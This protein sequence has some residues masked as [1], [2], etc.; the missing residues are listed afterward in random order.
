MQRG[1][2]EALRARLELQDALKIELDL[3]AGHPDLLPVSP[4]DHAAAANP[5]PWLLAADAKISSG[6]LSEEAPII[7]AA[8]W[9]LGRRPVPAI[10]LVERILYR[11]IID[12]L[13]KGLAQQR[14]PRDW[15]TFQRAPMNSGHQDGF[16]L[17]LDLAHFYATLNIELLGTELIERT[18]EWEATQALVSFLGR[19]SPSV[20]GIPQGSRASDRVGDTFAQTLHHRL[21][22]RGLECWQ[23]ADDY[24]IWAP[25]Y[26]AAIRALDSFDEEARKLGLFLNERKTTIKSLQAYEESV[27]RPIKALTQAWEDKRSEMADVDLYSDVE[28]EPD[29]VEVLQAVARAE[30]DA[31]AEKVNEFGKN[32]DLDPSAR[33]DL[34]VVIQT[35]HAG[36]DLEA[37]QHLPSLLQGES[38]HT[39]SI[40]QYLTDMLAT[41]ADEAWG[42]A[43]AA[44]QVDSLTE[45]QKMWLLDALALPVSGADSS[46]S[47]IRDWCREQLNTQ[48]SVTR[49][50]ALW[51]CA[52]QGQLTVEDWHTGLDSSGP[53]S[54]ERL[55]AASALVPELTA[56]SQLTDMTSV[57]IHDWAA[58]EHVAQP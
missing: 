43:A 41:N 58:S 34:K 40:C 36:E 51:T 28:I 46:R 24:R 4:A 52:V 21:V 29:E 10:P 26:S 54:K 55:A 30:L 49:A 27:N 5:Q 16:V 25:N 9:R 56:K 22:R 11:S 42:A 38:T 44:S 1:I 37:L 3:A 17:I 18:G 33:I 2:S 19:L 7:A 47:R 8:K 20:G 48:N 39:P 53:F 6:V 15:E 32:Y 50:Q 14:K 57:A 23:F 45:W 35:L 13:D 12:L 31:W